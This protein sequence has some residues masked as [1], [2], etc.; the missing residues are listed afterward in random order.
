[1]KMQRILVPVDFSSTEAAAI[2]FAESIAK[3]N[4]GRLIFVHVQEPPRYYA[5][6]MYYGVSEPETAQ[7]SKMLEEIKPSDASVP[8]EHHL[9]AGDPATEI[10]RVADEEGVDLI[11]VGSHGRT[12]LYRMLMG[13]V[14]ESIVRSAN[15]PVVVYKQRVLE[16]SQ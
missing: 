15:C 1:M 11:V 4:G 16:P 3:S 8:A 5:G 7:L 9:L 12:G 2:E 14:A 6:E 10:V 13:S